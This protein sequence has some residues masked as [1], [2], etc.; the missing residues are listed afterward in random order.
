MNHISRLHGGIHISFNK[1]TEGSL[2][3]DGMGAMLWHLRKHSVKVTLTYQKGYG[4]TRPSQSVKLV[5]ATEE[6]GKNTTLCSAS[7]RHQLRT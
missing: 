7:S 3:P 6:D 2:R 1:T 4:L 5:E